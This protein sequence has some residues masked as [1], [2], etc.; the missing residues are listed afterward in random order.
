VTQNLEQK[1]QRQEFGEHG[2][3]KL[4]RRISGTVKHVQNRYL[5]SRGCIV[6]EDQQRQD[7]QWPHGFSKISPE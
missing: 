3:T 5:K 1:P 2:E 4:D 6:T 7:H